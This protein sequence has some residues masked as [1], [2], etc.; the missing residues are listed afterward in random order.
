MALANVRNTVFDQNAYRVNVIT[1]DECTLDV[2]E[3]IYDFRQL[4]ICL[5][6]PH[7]TG[8]EAWRDLN[9]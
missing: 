4:V 5:P 7:L 2:I 9:H 8:V 6:H 1:P 3:M